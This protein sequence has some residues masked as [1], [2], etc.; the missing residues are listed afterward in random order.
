MEPRERWLAVL[1]HE[2][3]DRV[4]MDYRATGEAT[5]KLLKYMGLDNLS[6][7]FEKLHID[8]IVT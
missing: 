8:P 4:P 5:E 1:N 2:K 3:P 7:V 6:Q